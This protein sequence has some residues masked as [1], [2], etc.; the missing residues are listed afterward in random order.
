[1]DCVI[2]GRLKADK[3]TVFRDDEWCSDICRKKRFGELPVTEE[4]A[5]RLRRWHGRG[6][7]TFGSQPTELTDPWV[8]NAAGLPVRHLHDEGP[9]ASVYEITS[10]GDEVRWFQCGMKACGAKK[11]GERTYGGDV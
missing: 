9:W 8:N 10:L 7:V 11:S 5:A 4:E 1:M 3:P 6:P 2:C